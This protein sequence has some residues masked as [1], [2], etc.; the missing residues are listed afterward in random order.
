MSRVESGD[1][2][3]WDTPIQ[4]Q[5]APAGL[6]H[7]LFWSA[8][9]VHTGWTSCVQHDLVVFELSAIDDHS[10]NYC[11]L[12]EQ[13]YVEDPSEEVTWH[14][15]SVELKLGRV[16]ISA[17]W[18]ARLDDSPA[19]WDWCAAEAEKAFAAAAVLVGKR[20]RRG[21]AVESEPNSGRAP[22]THH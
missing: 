12:A 22:R 18:R 11:R 16:Y 6:I 4:L 1:E 13:E 14:D 7:A 2:P 10:D 20:V 17:H 3:D 5:L 19:E 8:E 15:W 21:L 9:S